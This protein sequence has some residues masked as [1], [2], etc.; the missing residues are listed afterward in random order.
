MVWLIGH[1]HNERGGN[2]DAQ[3]YRHR[4]TSRLYRGLPTEGV[5]P[6]PAEGCISDLRRGVYELTEKDG[7]GVEKVRSR[8]AASDFAPW[9]LV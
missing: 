2:S 8:A 3:T 1:R 4:A 6:V 5:C 9:P 7:L